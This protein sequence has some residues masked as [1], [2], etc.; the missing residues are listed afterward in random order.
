VSYIVT[1][2]RG[3]RRV[4]STV[5]ELGIRTG[6]SRSGSAPTAASASTRMPSRGPTEP[7]TSHSTTAEIPCSSAPTGVGSA[8]EPPGLRPASSSRPANAPPASA[9]ST[10][11]ARATTPEWSKRSAKRATLGHDRPTRHNGRAR[12]VA[13]AD[14]VIA[15]RSNHPGHARPD[16][17]TQVNGRLATLATRALVA[18]GI[19]QRFPKAVTAFRRPMILDPVDQ[20]IAGPMPLRVRPLA[21]QPP[22]VNAGR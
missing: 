12:P 20:P 14:S 8:R 9:G 6:P 5:G 17:P 3:E 4:V 1:W 7:G 19:E 11:E 16:M 22:M 21:V 13:E 15:P 18:Q 10:A 2:G